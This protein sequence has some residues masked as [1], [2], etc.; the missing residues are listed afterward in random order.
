M[1]L[2]RLDIERLTDS[3]NLL[4]R[5]P[6]NPKEFDEDLINEALDY[7]QAFINRRLRRAGVSTNQEINIELKLLALHI[8]KYYVTTS[9]NRSAEIKEDYSNAVNELERIIKSEI[10]VS[11]EAIKAGLQTIRMIRWKLKEKVCW[12]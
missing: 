5:N 9:V 6:A 4:P 3:D 2:N 12:N 7:T 8:F 1:I 10:E 11:T